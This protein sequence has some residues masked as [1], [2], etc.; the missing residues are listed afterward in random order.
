MSIKSSLKNRVA[1]YCNPA[2]HTYISTWMD[3]LRQVPLPLGVATDTSHSHLFSSHPQLY[4][5]FHSVMKYLPG[6][7]QQIIKDSH[8]LEDFMIQKV[9][10]NHST[11]DPNSPRGFI[12]SFLIHM[13]KVITTSGDGT[14]KPGQ[15]EITLEEEEQRSIK[16]PWCSS[17]SRS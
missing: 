1:V 17:Q 5:M 2:S 3:V 15:L 4:D 14:S 7:Q 16:S 9:K 11:L 6:P 10:H 8:K 12:D 13:Q